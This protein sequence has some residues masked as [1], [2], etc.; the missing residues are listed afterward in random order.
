M[1]QYTGMQD[2][3]FILLSN[4]MEWCKNIFKKFNFDYIDKEIEGYSK[5]ITDLII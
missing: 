4:D 3:W 1:K 5:E 2:I